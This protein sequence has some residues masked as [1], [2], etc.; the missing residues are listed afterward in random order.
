MDLSSMPKG[1]PSVGLPLCL[2]CAEYV[3][4]LSA[5]CPHCGQT[6]TEPG[7]RYKEEGFYAR[8][9]LERLLEVMQRAKATTPTPDKEHATKGDF[10]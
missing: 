2:H 8:D 1:K 3:R 10:E 9:A 7:G 6:P 5:E 4:D